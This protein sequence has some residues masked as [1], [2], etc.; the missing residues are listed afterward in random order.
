MLKEALP[1]VARIEVVYEPASVASV[2]E[3]KDVL[4]VAARALGL[5]I[6]PWEVRDAGGFEKV[7]A[8]LNKQRPDGLYPLTAG[9]LMRPNR[10]RIAVFAS[11]G[12]LPSVYS[13]RE[14][15]EAGGL[16]SYGRDLADNYRRVAYYV[17]RILKGAS[18]RSA[19]G[20]AD[21]V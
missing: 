11:K 3:V 17:D 16:M 12:R 20:A 8:A 6:Q 14:A 21:E 1:K 5:T 15:V 2:I 13:S 4:P 19:R 10:K 7:F 18:C 9:G